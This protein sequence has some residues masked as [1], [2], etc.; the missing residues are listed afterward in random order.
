VSGGRRH[1]GRPIKQ[2]EVR[3]YDR[4]ASSMHSVLWDIVTRHAILQRHTA[5]AW[6]CRQ[7]NGWAKPGY[8]TREIAL[9][10]ADLMQ[11]LGMPDVTEAYLCRQADG[12]A[13]I[14]EHWHLRKRR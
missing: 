13:Q 4:E 5:R 1:I 7:E 11:V 3:R 2:R 12:R 14:G 9:R 6:M 10:V 8:R